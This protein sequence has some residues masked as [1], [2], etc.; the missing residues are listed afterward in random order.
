MKAGGGI[1]E[2]MEYFYPALHRG[3][4]VSAHLGLL[5]WGLSRLGHE[6]WN[7]EGERSGVLQVK[8][9]TWASGE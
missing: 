3:G 9:N 6:G 1:G 7:L 2:E 5:A 4:S 8:W